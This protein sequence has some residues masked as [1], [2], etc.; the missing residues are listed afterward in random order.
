MARSRGYLSLGGA[1]RRSWGQPGA[2]FLRPTGS[3]TRSATSG[4]VTPPPD[5]S[6]RCARIRSGSGSPEGRVA[7]VRV[8][9]ALDE[10]EDGLRAPLVWWTPRRRRTCPRSRSERAEASPRSS[11]QRRSSWSRSPARP[12]VRSLSSSPSE[13]ALRRW[14]QRASIDERQGPKGALTTTEKEELSRLRREVR[15]LRM[16]RDFQTSFTGLI[17]LA[18]PADRD[19]DPGDDQDADLGNQDGPIRGI[20]L[21]RSWRSRS[22]VARNHP[23]TIERV[24]SNG[25]SHR[26]SVLPAAEPPRTVATCR[27]G[28]H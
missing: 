8:V 4:V 26:K 18:D 21:R 14:V 17:R 23:T 5:G 9:P 16:Q 12:L 22:R 7:P 25:A 11:R 13:T 10:L 20:K 15:T 28:P 1:D 24:E 6:A 27:Q 3:S 19:G 2:S